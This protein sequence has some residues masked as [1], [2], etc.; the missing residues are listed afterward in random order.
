MAKKAS[1]P[2][3]RIAKAITEVNPNIKPAEAD[4][5]AWLIWFKQA[6]P[7]T[8]TALKGDDECTSELYEQLSG[9]FLAPTGTPPP[10]EEGKP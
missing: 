8:V 4:K 9:R 1:K 10:D 7:K 6:C 3:Q 2:W 5:E